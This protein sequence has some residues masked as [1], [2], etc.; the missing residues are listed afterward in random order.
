MGTRR[1]RIDLTTKGLVHIGNGRS[2]GKKD[3]FLQQGKIAV[4]DAKAFVSRLDEKRLEDY[5]RFL[6]TDSRSGLD[7]FLDKHD[8][9]GVAE[10]AVAYRLDAAL[11][12]KNGRRR[13]REVGEFV[14]DAYGCPYVPGSSFKGMLRTVLLSALIE[15]GP[16]AFLQG[17]PQNGGWRRD[18]D[19]AAGIER[20]AFRGGDPRAVSDIMRFVSV[21]DSD[22]LDAGDLVFAEKYDKFSKGD[23]AE[24]K[25]RR[26]GRSANAGVGGNDL[27]IYRECLRPGTV[28]TLHVGIDERI[29]ERLPFPLDEDGLASLFQ[30]FDARYR[31]CFLDAF[32]FE[33]S[34]GG[35]AGGSGGADDGM[36]RYVIKSGPFEGKRCRN[37]AIAGT[38]YCNMHQDEAAAPSG[39]LSKHGGLTCYLGG[40]VD[41]DSKTVLNAL[42]ACDAERLRETALI[43][44]AQFPTK[45]DDRFSGGRH[46]ALWDKVEGEGFRPMTVKF[47]DGA[48][49]KA[50]DDHRHWM[51]EDLGVSP[52]TMKLGKVGD[53]LLPMGKCS[54]CIVAEPL[55]GGFEGGAVR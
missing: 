14:K 49:S 13:N 29:D 55:Q 11:K 19:A 44:Y 15:E 36:C 38:G 12:G 28:A 40:G 27:S 48:V 17:Y 32:E 42:F 50:K 1:Y 35:G 37:H 30:R 26:G 18:K 7:D 6:E 22:P 54:L 41:F 9:R 39:A 5:C 46:R 21:S 52:H 47:G 43:L 16:E 4:L 24:H 20:Q 51:D 2:L 45:I 23:A 31:K 53:E 10:K 34:P 3:Y 33:E 25:R 8:L